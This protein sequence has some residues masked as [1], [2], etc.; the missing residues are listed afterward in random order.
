SAAAPKAGHT[1]A[2]RRKR[3]IEN[4][5]HAGGCDPAA[6]VLGV[7]TPRTTAERPRGTGEYTRS[8]AHSQPPRVGLTQRVS[9]SGRRWPCRAARSGAA[10]G[11]AGG[12]PRNA[13]LRRQKF[14]SALFP[15]HLDRVAD[16]NISAPDRIAVHAEISRRRGGGEWAQRIVRLEE[17]KATVVVLD[18]EP[19]DR[20]LVGGLRAFGLESPEPGERPAGCQQAAFHGEPRPAARRA[21]R[22]VRSSSS[23]TGRMPPR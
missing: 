6:R 18:D 21:S 9:A 14:V 10:G 1:T 5:L 19:V 15:D 22:R 23:V 4:S 7:G 17:D 3:L 12:Q 8:A 16:V 20:S 2:E 11:R 13:D